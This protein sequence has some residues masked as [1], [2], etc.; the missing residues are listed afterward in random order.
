MLILFDHSLST[1]K[2]DLSSEKKDDTKT[3]DHQIILTD[4]DLRA[5]KDYY[6]RITSDD[7]SGPVTIDGEFGTRFI[8]VIV[9]VTDTA[10]RELSDVTVTID[11]ETGITADNGETEFELSDGDVTIFV[12]K[13]DIDKELQA[14][15]E[16]PDEDADPQT[17]TL[18]LGESDTVDVT[19]S[20]SK[21][22]GLSIFRIVGIFMVIIAAAGAAYF[23]II[24]RRIGKPGKSAGD[25]L[26]AENYVQPIAPPVLPA[27]PHNSKPEPASNSPVHHES[28]AELVKQKT[29]ASKRPSSTHPAPVSSAINLSPTGQEIPR[30][31]S[32]KEM[33]QLPESDKPKED[34]PLKDDLPTSPEP[35]KQ[36]H[37]TKKP[38]PQNEIIIEH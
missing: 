11:G 23:F 34:L 7:G 6:I 5:G 24:R 21:N 25:I 8:P 31:T 14:T 36:H 26:E 33:V 17:I 18:A 35:A 15:V 20:A 27:L 29:E 12:S 1:D 38:D 32:L 19:N 2:N 22:G 16:V 10:D 3:T 13:G 28:I 4:S 37:S 30:H 9:K